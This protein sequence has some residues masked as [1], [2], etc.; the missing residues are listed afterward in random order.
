MRDLSKALENIRK[1]M[2]DQDSEFRR[3]EGLGPKKSEPH[4]K[5]P[6][7][8]PEPEPQLSQEDSGGNLAPDRFLNTSIAQEPAPAPEMPSE[9]QPQ[10]T[11]QAQ[12]TAPE[13]V[14]VIPQKDSRHSWLYNEVAKAVQN[15]SD[16]SP[17][18]KVVAVFVPVVQNGQE[19]ED[20]PVHTSVELPPVNEEDFKIE[21]EI[22]IQDD[23]DG[24]EQEPDEPEVLVVAVPDTTEL[25]VQLDSEPEPME[26]EEAAST[27]SEPQE[28][29][30]HD[31][32]E[33][34]TMQPE[35]P[36][37]TEP[38][39]DIP[40]ELSAE[41]EQ[42][43]HLSELIPESIEHPDPELAE[44][45]STMEEKLDESIAAENEQPEPE[46]TAEISEEVS[47]LPDVDMSEFD[48]TEDEDFSEGEKIPFT[49]ITP[50]DD[51]A[52][53]PDTELTAENDAALHDVEIPADDGA[54][55]PDTE[56]TTEDSEALPELELP[57]ELEDDEVIDD[58][59]APTENPKPI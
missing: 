7:L 29:E 20:L 39:P 2:R 56:T 48:I 49:E 11:P 10:D 15:A 30:E 41:P 31:I 28:P 19:F 35:E 33:D 9:P 38:E 57:D 53:L 21:D 14:E 50:A 12:D 40:E 58:I 13:F 3:E 54:A 43:E 16:G 55:L 1:A 25:E 4:P 51:G 32:S 52:A 47:E 37:I 17:N 5:I 42:A 8:K 36:A 45:F 18:T 26:L 59:D 24:N 6:S 27:D 23:P 22:D 46:E 44:A 34:D